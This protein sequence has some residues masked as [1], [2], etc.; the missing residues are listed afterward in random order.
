MTGMAGLQSAPSHD[1]D[2]YLK[3]GYGQPSTKK[4]WPLSAMIIVC[5]LT[6]AVAMLVLLNIVGVQL[7][8]GGYDEKVGGTVADWGAV[9]VPLVGIPFAFWLGLRQFDLENKKAHREDREDHHQQV[10]RTAE[11]LRSVQLDAAVRN[12]VD[13]P[14][15]ATETE[16]RD[17]AAWTNEMRQRGWVKDETPQQWRNSGSISSTDTLLLHDEVNHLL[18]RPWIATVLCTNTSTSSM[19]VSS[20]QVT[21]QDGSIEALP[22]DDLR[23]S[24]GQTNTRRVPCPNPTLIAFPSPGDAAVSIVSITAVVSDEM[25]MTAPIVGSVRPFLREATS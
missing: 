13:F 12:I 9:L 4:I 21:R 1:L 15:L 6:F 17:I 20:L 2:A 25:G 18:L 22:L 19:M 14:D 3:V 8:G 10:I 16:R 11:F 23:L 24:P 7:G 5:L